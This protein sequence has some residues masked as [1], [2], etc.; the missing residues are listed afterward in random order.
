MEIRKLKKHP[1]AQAGVYLDPIT[2]EW[3]LLS[4]TTKVIIIRDK[5][6][7]PTGTYS[8]TTARHIAWFLAERFPC[9]TYQDIKSL[10][11]T[12]SAWD[13]DKGPCPLTQEEKMEIKRIRNQVR[14]I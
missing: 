3:G 9:F 8:N 12:E 2:G 7:I 10:I 4:Y 1:Y 14:Y 5:R 13:L 6:M 11:I